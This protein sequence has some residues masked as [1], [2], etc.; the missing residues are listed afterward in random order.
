MRIGRDLFLGDFLDTTNHK[1]KL[2]ALVGAVIGLY[3]SLEVAASV[4]ESG[5]NGLIL[6]SLGATAVLLF[7][8]PRAALSQPWNVLGGHA[9]AAM[10][11]VAV[12]H[13]VD[14]PLVAAALAVGLTVYAMYYLRC[15]HPPG[16]ATALYAVIGGASVEEL[17]LL[18][19][20]HPVLSSVAV[21]L[22]VAVAINYPF[23]WRRYPAALARLSEPSPTDPSGAL[24]RSGMS[25][26]DL[27][28]AMRDLNLYLD[29]TEDDL[30]RLYLLARRHHEHPD[31]IELDDIQSG[32]CYSNGAQDGAWSVRKVLARDDGQVTYR[33]ISGAGVP[34]EGHCPVADF[35]A[36]AHHRVDAR[37]WPSQ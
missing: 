31:A 36:W 19:I 34:E 23:P 37:E 30:A 11:G 4:T 28:H 10:V 22:L 7:A 33:V 13:A 1:D 14:H 35:V 3:L 12:R 24:E 17:G 18:F 32:Q 26:A 27:E 2:I 21:M 20:L 25:Q 16:G 6:A 8:A 29:L 15:L 9:I 5:I